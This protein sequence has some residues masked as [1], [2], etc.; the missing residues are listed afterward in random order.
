MMYIIIAILLLVVALQIIGNLKDIRK[1]K[2]A[3]SKEPPQPEYRT[4]DF[5]FSDNERYPY[6]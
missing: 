6:E 5:S 3:F 4:E 2:D 1:Q